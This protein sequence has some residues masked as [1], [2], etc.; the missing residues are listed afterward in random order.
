MDEKEWEDKF[1]KEGKE[2]AELQSWIVNTHWPQKA[3][4]GSECVLSSPL[5]SPSIV[6]TSLA[7]AGL[8]S[9]R[10][11]CMR[12]SSAYRFSRHIVSSLT[13]EFSPSILACEVSS[14]TTSGGHKW[15][16]QGIASM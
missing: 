11:D 7:L 13:S 10:M 6:L 8:S 5:S 12:A 15:R 4:S 16:V 9:S 14:D 1:A 2:A 3:A